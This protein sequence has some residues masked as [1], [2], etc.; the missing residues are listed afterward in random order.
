MH[1]EKAVEEHAV[2]LDGAIGLAEPRVQISQRLQSLRVARYFAQNRLVG[3][4]GV[5]ESVPL[6]T[7]RGALQVFADVNAH[8]YLRKLSGIGPT[9][10]TGR[11]QRQYIPSEIRPKTSKAYR[12]CRNVN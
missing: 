12:R 10:L 11:S 5:F 3:L 2:I 8:R 9:R 1:L 4:H 6:E 7:P